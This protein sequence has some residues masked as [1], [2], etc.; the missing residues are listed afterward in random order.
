MTPSQINDHTK[1]NRKT[2]RT[3]DEHIKMVDT[4]LAFELPI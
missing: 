4:A 3:L 2:T 1:S